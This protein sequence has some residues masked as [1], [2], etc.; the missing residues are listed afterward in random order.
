M[1]PPSQVAALAARDAEAPHTLEALYQQV[2]SG[3]L[4]NGRSRTPGGGLL[5]ELEQAFTEHPLLA[6]RLLHAWG[7]ESRAIAYLQHSVATSTDRGGHF[8]EILD[9]AGLLIKWGQA[10]IA[11]PHLKHLIETSH[12]TLFILH[13]AAHL[14]EAGEG[15]SAAAALHR[16]LQ[17]RDLYPSH[18]VQ[19]IELLCASGDTGELKRLESLLAN[20]DADIAFMAARIIG[21][22]GDRTI[23]DAFFSQ[24]APTSPPEHL[25]QMAELY[26]AWGDLERSEHYLSQLSENNIE[27]MVLR[28]TRLLDRLGRRSEAVDL[29]TRSHSW[30]IEIVKLLYDWG[31]TAAAETKCLKFVDDWVSPLL[32]FGDALKLWARWGDRKL[33]REAMLQTIDRSDA[34]VSP[35]TF[36]Q[37]IEG[38]IAI[39]DFATARSLFRKY[40]PTVPHDDSMAAYYFQ[41]FAQLEPPAAVEVT[42]ESCLRVCRESGKQYISNYLLT[43]FL[44]MLESPPRP[45][46]TQLTTDAE[47][48]RRLCRRLRGRRSAPA[49]G[50]D[51]RGARQRPRHHGHEGEVSELVEIEQRHA[52]TRDIDWLATARLGEDRRVQGMVMAR[53]RTA[54]G[55]RPTMI[56]IDPACIAGIPVRSLAIL[57][58]TIAQHTLQGRD[59]VGLLIGEKET[60]LPPRPSHHQ[61]EAILRAVAEAKIPS[62]TQSQLP[63]QLEAL[64]LRRFLRPGTMLYLIG[65]LTTMAPARL[66]RLHT[67]LHA[68]GVTVQPVATRSTFPV[69]TIEWGI[70]RTRWRTRD[71][72]NILNRLLLGRHIPDV[73]SALQRTGTVVFDLATAD[74]ETLAVRVGKA[75]WIDPS[76]EPDIVAELAGRAA[77]A[78]V[79]APAVGIAAD[80]LHTASGYPQY[81][82][83][84]ER[85]SLYDLYRDLQLGTLE[86]EDP[87]GTL[88]KRV[89]NAV[90]IAEKVVRRA[91]QARW[92]LSHLDLHFR[93]LVEQ[94]FDAVLKLWDRESEA[95]RNDFQAMRERLATMGRAVRGGASQ[96]VSAIAQGGRAIARG[97]SAA[98][99]TVL[100]LTDSGVMARIFFRWTRPWLRLAP[101]PHGRAQYL[102]EQFGGHFVGGAFHAGETITPATLGEDGPHVVRGR[103]NPDRQPVDAHTLQPVGGTVHTESV[104][105]GQVAYALNPNPVTHPL[106]ETPLAALPT[107]GPQYYGATLY[108]DLTAGPSLA[109]IAAVAPQLAQQWTTLVSRLQDRPLREAL[110]AIQR[111]VTQ[112][113][114][115]RYRHYRSRRGRVLW[116]KLSEKVDFGTATLLDSLRT[117]VQMKGG[118]CLELSIAALS[119]LRATGIP[120]GLSRGWLTSR[121]GRVG[122]TAHAWPE[123]VLPTAEGRWIGLPLEATPS[124]SLRIGRFMAEGPAPAT[125]LLPGATPEVPETGEDTAGEVAESPPVAADVA[126]S[127][128][129]SAGRDPLSGLFQR[130]R[131]GSL[132]QRAELLAAA[133]ALGLWLS[134]GT[135]PFFGS[136]TTWEA[137]LHDH[138]AA[139][140]TNAARGEDPADD[141]ESALRRQIDTLIADATQRLGAAHVDPRVDA[142]R[143]AIETFLA[144]SPRGSGE[145]GVS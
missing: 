108:A 140:V 25:L 126:V 37:G 57:A 79:T 121:R 103:V 82:T 129:S 128:V 112:R 13:A 96:T 115:L 33:A 27:D 66:E 94:G 141:S 89:R 51:N 104:P 42:L 5:T 92:R 74:P 69:P 127:T 85:H 77:S 133:N 64:H 10:G 48:I 130:W 16:L 61:L 21:T 111:E 88:K 38:L 93:D 86:L 123:V 87:L 31:E 107:A 110:V 109:E 119:L 99:D 49:L 145:N 90:K 6:A 46:A 30:P 100:R 102:R 143:T 138:F 9:A 59:P 136:D 60:F 98:V 144:G 135:R 83:R 114:G 54:T 137:Y 117:T 11:V 18:A 28:V 101:A 116:K 72:Q 41:L 131:T 40:L 43:T 3:V 58:G 132:S 50:F 14:K 97:V 17:Y 32:L 120:A 36:R 53:R 106:L 142:W 35:W 122:T 45:P 73:K 75:L 1:V 47:S 63:A 113:S 4:Q 125:A 70:G 71:I 2:R 139:F 134:S 52:D 8:G 118:K 62:S 20:K 124:P 29:L 65:D 12:D 39:G 44:E 56:V 26:E 19:A 7:E 95:L 91:R 22:Y 55:A 78:N 23:A 84:R 81:M 105:E 15:F 76:K 24:Q 68:R 34:S 80:T 67:T